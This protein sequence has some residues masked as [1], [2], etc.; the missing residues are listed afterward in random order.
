MGTWIIQRRLSR[1]RY[2]SI[3]IRPHTL[4]TIWIWPIARLLKD[5]RIPLFPFLRLNDVVSDRVSSVL[6]FYLSRLYR[7]LYVRPLHM[8]LH[9]AG[10]W[11]GP[12]DNLHLL[13]HPAD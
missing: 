7:L 9:R 4:I 5:L 6:A 1:D 11:G 8:A 2:I 13:L 3:F 12:G 10:R